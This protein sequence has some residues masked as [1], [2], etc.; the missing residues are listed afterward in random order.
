[1]SVGTWAWI[2]VGILVALFIIITIVRQIPQ[3]R[4]YFRIKAM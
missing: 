3:A 1:V 4:R 2:I